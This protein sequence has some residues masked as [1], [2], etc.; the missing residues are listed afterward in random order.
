MTK[1]YDCDTEETTIELD[2]LV[3]AEENVTCVFCAKCFR[4]LAV[5]Y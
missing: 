1:C 3:D 4:L 2:W 5:R